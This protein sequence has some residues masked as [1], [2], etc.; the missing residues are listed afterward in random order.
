MPSPLDRF[1]TAIGYPEKASDGATSFPLLVDDGEVLVRAEAGR[2]VLSRVLSRDPED[3]PR[4]VGDEARVGEDAHACTAPVEPVVHAAGDVVAGG[5]GGNCDAAHV[6]GALHDPEPGG[7]AGDAVLELAG[8]GGPGADGDVIAPDQG[9][10]AADVVA[11]L[12]GDAH[13]VH[14]PEGQA[15]RAQ[16]GVDAPA[17]DA[18]V[19][20]DMGAAGGQEQAVALRPAGDGM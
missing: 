17:G 10:Q 14:V 1:L 15:Q 6:K 5:E 7:D 16:R 18:G 3:L 11:V 19:H 13:G 2:L 20:Q 12:V 9:G 4:L 8:G